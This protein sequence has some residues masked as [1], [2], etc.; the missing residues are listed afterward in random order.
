M[1]DHNKFW[2][3]A[4]VTFYFTFFRIVVY[5]LVGFLLKEM[6]RIQKTVA[7]STWIQKHKNL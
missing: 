4:I 5:L 6:Q 1:F 7:I 2:Y 3:K